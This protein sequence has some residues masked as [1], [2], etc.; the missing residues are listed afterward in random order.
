MTTYT[1]IAKRIAKIIISPDTA[2]G[3]THGV[4]SV[5][6]DLGYL[7]YGY[8]DTD[9]R[10]NRETER[11]RLINAIRFGIL[12]NENF[13]RTIETVLENFNQYVPENN[14]D[15]LYAKTGASV[16]GRAITN[17]LISKKIATS[18]AQRS[19]LMIALRGGV[20]GNILLAG[21]MA[22][23]SIYR[24][25]RLQMTDPDI[26][27]EL[28]K[29]DYD[30]LYFLVEPALQ[31]FIEAL[32]VRRTQGNTAFNQIIELVEKEVRYGR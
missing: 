24:S 4:L 15:G 8:F 5:P 2:I 17:S 3:L 20:V 29:K 12:Q 23:R 18:I 6:Q 28:R 1:E 7:A 25:Q 11:I 9:S 19:S 26:Y 22:E 31:P 13:V 27:Y 10:F 32:R 30:F 21:G 14:R 16:V